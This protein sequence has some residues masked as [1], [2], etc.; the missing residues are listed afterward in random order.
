MVDYRYKILI[1]LRLRKMPWLETPRIAMN[2]R[3]TSNA[4]MVRQVAPGRTEIGSI[5]NQERV[6][7]REEAR[8]VR[9]QLGDLFN[10]VNQQDGI[11]LE[12]DWIQCY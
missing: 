5:A 6:R 10:S 8:E 1:A 11:D 9:K 3:E 7:I 12:K 2:D 4:I